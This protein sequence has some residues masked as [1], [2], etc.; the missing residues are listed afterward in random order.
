MYND[1]LHCDIGYTRSNFLMDSA[2]LR[3]TFSNT[4]NTSFITIKAM[5]LAEKCANPYAV[6]AQDN[7]PHVSNQDQEDLN[8]N[9]VGD[10]CEGCK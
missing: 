5:P 9:D 7:C 4:L 1:V 6:N 8:N 10:A 3:P 2:L